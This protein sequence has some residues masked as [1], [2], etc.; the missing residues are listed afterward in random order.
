MEQDRLNQREKRQG[1]A[2]ACPASTTVST[3]FRCSRTDRPQISVRRLSALTAPVWCYYSSNPLVKTI[4]ARR[5]LHPYSSCRRNNLHCK[6][7]ATPSLFFCCGEERG[8]WV[9]FHHVEENYAETHSSEKTTVLI[10]RSPPV[11]W[12]WLQRKRQKWFDL[13]NLCSTRVACYMKQI[14]Y[15]RNVTTFPSPCATVVVWKSM[16]SVSIHL[17][18]FLQSGS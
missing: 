7:E 1:R 14:K 13:K 18:H 15:K 5:L 11:N 8:H 2:E 3:Q 16:H 9:Y 12:K 4:W 10:W 17:F 6:P